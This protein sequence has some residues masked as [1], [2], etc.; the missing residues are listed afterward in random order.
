METRASYVVVGTFVLALTAAAFGVVLF[1]TRTSFED[2]PKTYI[3]YFTG[4][5][6]G[7]QIGSPVR[8]RGVPVG[9]VNDIRIE[10]TDVE[11]V[12]VTMEIVQGTPIKTD[13]SSTLGLQG[14]TGVAY[15][16]LTGGTRD[17]KPLTAVADAKVP[18]IPSKTSGIQQVL[19]SAPELLERAVAITE[20]L[21]LILDDRNVESIANTLDNLSSLTG[22]LAG[23][24]SQIEQLI[25]DSQK[26]FAALREAA[27]G[28]SELT[29][30]LNRKVG[31]LADDADDILTDV[32]KAVRGFNRIANQ[33][34]LVVDENRASI[35]DFSSGGLYELSQFI[36]EGRVLI[37]ALTRLSAQIERDPARFFF[38]DNQKGFE[39]K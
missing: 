13:T 2:T 1:L 3:S 24:S 33:L 21:A 35:R 30:G 32:H 22:T 36:A 29:N 25:G 27:D 17:S 23:S 9:T 12:R 15:I 8:Y 31:P 28:V 16:E 26:T 10:P 14:I 39:A 5:V 7:L 38:G 19:A 37:S 4:S 20:R 34:E 6:T 18:V 11:R